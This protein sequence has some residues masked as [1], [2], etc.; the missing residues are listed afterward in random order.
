MIITDDIAIEPILDFNLYRDAIVNIIR[1]SYPKFTIGIFVDWGTGKSTLMDSVDKK[2]QHEDEDIVIVRFETWR[3]EREEQF[4]LIPLLKTIAFALPEEE[5]FQNLKQKLKRGAINFIKTP[6]IISSILSKY[7]TEDMGMI[8]KEAFDSFKKE[9][10]SKMELL[11]EVDRDTLYFDGSD[12]I[13][14]EIT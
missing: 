6:D 8:T 3:Y 13:K 10:N 1:N 2:L 7:I 4:A 12:D 5:Q 11:A 9:F 14:N